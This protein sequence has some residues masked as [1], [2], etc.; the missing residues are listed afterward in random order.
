MA[1]FLKRFVMI[2]CVFALTISVIPSYIPETKAAEVYEY[3]YSL[4]TTDYEKT[5]YRA[6]SNGI[7]NCE[8][9]IEFGIAPK[10]YQDSLKQQ[11]V[12]EIIQATYKAL[13]LVMAD[14]PEY[15]WFDGYGNI[16]I[17][18]DTL[19]T[20][21]VVF[22]VKEY[23][24]GGKTVTK[25]NVNQFIQ[26][27][28]AAANKALK[29]MPTDKDL[30][31]IHYLHD[32]LASN[33][34]YVI[35]DDDQ[36]IYGALV[37]GQAVCAG[38]SKAY[39]YLL[40][41]AGIRSWYVTGTSLSPNTMNKVAHGWNLVYLD[42]KCYYTDVTWDDQNEI[43]HAYY[44]LSK[45][46]IGESH[47]PD[48]PEELP[49]ACSDT[50]LDYFEVH[51]GAGSGVGMLKGNYNASKLASYMKKVSD[52]TWC[53]HVEDLTGGSPRAF[54]MWLEQ[55]NGEMANAV[56]S[57]LG[58]IGSYTWSLDILWDEYHISIKAL[59]NTHKHSILAYPAKVPT[60]TASGNSQYFVC[61]TCGEWYSDVFFQ[62]KIH[63]KDSVKIPALD[64]KYTQLKQDADQH[65]YV[66]TDC[67]EVKPDSQAMHYDNNKNGKCDVCNAYV[68]V[69]TEPTSP[70]TESTTTTVA[71]SEPHEST[72][73]PNERPTEETI[74]P[75]EPSGEATEPS[76]DVTDGA[77][78]P[79][80]GT[81]P[82]VPS[83]TEV[84]TQGGNAS[85]TAEDINVTAIS[86]FIGAAVAAYG[87][88]TAQ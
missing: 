6:F 86:I 62:N 33:I 5:A 38:Y 34:D 50:G 37:G 64:H 73:K 59:A 72:E 66:C 42:G 7:Q 11:Y 44:M 28:E 21:K 46:E 80:E 17:Y 9:S 25:S 60:C 13:R 31:K 87:V 51:E 30:A 22:E 53:V 52:D 71:P 75:T 14:H 29:D 83:G 47:F 15:F 58:I 20:Y 23:S 2:L 63:D 57:A 68:E 77:T 49:P 78:E 19:T 32:Y 10:N 8:T 12:N 65:W 76:T 16:S 61:K 81:E 85:D 82:T 3:G 43:F 84:P 24:A 39:Q 41:K 79:T 48:H 88:N 74:N 1:T 4:L 67:G 27:V 26:Q 55:N 35:N 40:A 45:A 69:P 56:A 70:G 36:T 54:V 18:H